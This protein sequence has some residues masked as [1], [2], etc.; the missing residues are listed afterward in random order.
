MEIDY[1]NVANDIVSVVCRFNILRSSKKLL[2]ISLK[3]VF[4]KRNNFP[5][6][7]GS[8]FFVSSIVAMEN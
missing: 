6:S 7:I 8:R 4:S 2:L 1:K 3:W 5:S